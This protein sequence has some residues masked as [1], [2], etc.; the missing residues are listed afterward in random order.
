M[1]SGKSHCVEQ[2]F[3]GRPDSVAKVR[4]WAREY[5][6]CHDASKAAVDDA[7][8][9][10]S[11]LASNAVEHTR[12]GGPNGCFTVL[13]RCVNRDGGTTHLRMEVID[14][15]SSTAPVAR[16]LDP[17][18]IN[19]QHFGARGRGLALVEV[20]AEQWWVRGDNRSWTVT[21]EIAVARTPTRLPVLE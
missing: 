19:Q 7:V 3:P 13:L 8:L 20:V 11:E 5:W 17:L 12:S 14:A 2:S 15:G 6:T 9:V 21:A 1:C 16:T 4:V 10:L 18:A